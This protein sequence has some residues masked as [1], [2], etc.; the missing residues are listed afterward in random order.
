M[1][2]TMSPEGSGGSFR[3]ELPSM[4]AAATHVSEVKGNISTQLTQLMD[5]LA[6]LEGTWQGQAATSFHMLKQR[7]LDDASKLSVA[8]D[9]IAEKLRQSEKGYAQSEEAG[10]TSFSQ[11]T[12]RLG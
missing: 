10:A 1:E 4:Q 9:G 5:K 11:I 7:W 8:L 3:T 2:D 6:P 12:N